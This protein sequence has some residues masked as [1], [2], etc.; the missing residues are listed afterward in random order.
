MI[1]TDMDIGSTSID[2]GNRRD[3]TTNMDIGNTTTDMDI[4]NTT[5]V[6]D[7]GN[8]INMDTVHGKSYM[9]YIVH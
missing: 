3:T 6:M 2:L 4:G 9:A 5:T 8:T 7:I 1:E